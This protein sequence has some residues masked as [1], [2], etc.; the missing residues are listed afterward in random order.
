MAASASG[1]EMRGVIRSFPVAG[2]TLPVLRGVNIEVPPGTL[3]VVCGPSGSGKTTLLH[4]AALLD[5]PDAGEVRLDGLDAGARSE[6]ERD[7]LRRDAVG[8]IFQRFHLVPQWTALENVMVRFRYL[9]IPRR[10]AMDRARAALVVVGLEG[11]AD[12]RAGLLSGGEMQR[13]ALARAVVY[14]PRLLLADEPVGQ[15][16]APNARVLLALLEQMC[17]EGAAVLVAAHDRRLW[18]RA[19]RV[20]RLKDGVLHTAGSE[21]V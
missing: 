19:D 12:R 9:D 14:P 1:L 7:R 6:V 3:A 18:A 15:V 10:E 20:Y 4:L 16:D 21:G 8:M 5:R 13:V 17:S 2:G 11:A